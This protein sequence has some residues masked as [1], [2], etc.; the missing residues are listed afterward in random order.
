MAPEILQQMGHGFCVDYWGL[1]M[2][3]YEMMTGLPPWYTTEDRAILYKRLKSAPLDIP[4]YFSPQVSSICFNLLQRDPRRR[5]GVRGMKTVMAHE[6]FHGMNFRDLIYKLIDAPIRPCEGWKRVDHAEQKRSAKNAVNN[7]NGI[8]R[9]PRDLDAAT[10][11]F[12]EH[13]TRM[14]VNSV[15]DHDES[16]YSSDELEGED[17]NENTFLGFTY[18]EDSISG[19]KQKVRS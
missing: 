16:G 11:N 5:L 15:N 14:A 10:A 3:V 9:I 12:D 19:A 18:D 6:F 4:G 17:L 8:P 1:G 2:L 7:R 13:F